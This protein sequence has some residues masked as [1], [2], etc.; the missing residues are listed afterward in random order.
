M[1]ALQEKRSLII[2]GKNL[3]HEKAFKRTMAASE[4]AATLVAWESG[5]RLTTG[6]EIRGGWRYGC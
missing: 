2:Q 3:E 6:S 5:C 1:I 4:S